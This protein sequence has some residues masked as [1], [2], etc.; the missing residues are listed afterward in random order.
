MKIELEKP[1]FNKKQMG[2]MYE[3]MRS[4]LGDQN[5]DGCGTFRKKFIQV[6]DLLLRLI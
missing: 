4:S 1:G 3:E 6:C 2:V 5:A